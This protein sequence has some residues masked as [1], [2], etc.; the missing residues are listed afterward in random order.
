MT[1]TRAVDMAA[2]E[3]F[4]Q[5]LRDCG[6]TVKM[7]I[8]SG[9]EMKRQRLKAADFIFK[10]C[11]K[12]KKIDKDSVFD[13]DVVEISDIKDTDRYHGG[14]LFVPSVAEQYCKKGRR[15]TA[16][17]A[18]QCDGVGPQSYGTTYEVV[19]YD[20]NH[21]LIPLLFAHFIGAECFET[22]MTMLE[23]CSNTPGF[24]IAERTTIVD[25]K[26]KHG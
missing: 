19:T 24:D 8:I 6:H 5:L 18:A 14:F 23:E 12:T 11:Q 10:Q 21:H 22:W 3:G 2:L 20:T 13:R 26:K 4:T 9:V 1:A 16:A 25:Q 17:D 7:F 15:T